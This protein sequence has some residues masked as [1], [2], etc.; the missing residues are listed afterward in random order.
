MKFNIDPDRPL[1][2]ERPIGD[3]FEFE[4]IQ[5]EVI[6]DTELTFCKECFFSGKKTKHRHIT[7]GCVK[8]H[9]TDGNFVIFKEVES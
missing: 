2:P 4:G 6:K 3:R 5:L 1:G 9:R 7:G 8:K